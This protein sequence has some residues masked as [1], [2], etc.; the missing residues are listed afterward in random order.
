MHRSFSK[1]VS[2]CHNKHLYLNI[3][4]KNTPH[5]TRQVY[6]AKT[7]DEEEVGKASVTASSASRR[8]CAACRRR[9]VRQR[10][11]SFCCTEF[12]ARPPD[13]FHKCRF[14]GGKRYRPTRTRR[15]RVQRC[16]AVSP[17]SNVS[18][19]IPPPSAASV[20]CR[21]SAGVMK[22][23]AVVIAGGLSL[24]TALAFAIAFDVAVAFGATMVLSAWVGVVLVLAA[25]PASS[26]AQAPADVVDVVETPATRNRFGRRMAGRR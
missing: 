24:A 11:G 14:V 23:F 13:K 1:F 2:G 9:A 18:E 15:K 12:T 19:T 10:P 7:E 3:R 8:R 26:P 22:S 4:T 5:S 25:A 21:G 20:I 16:T 17:V 6:V